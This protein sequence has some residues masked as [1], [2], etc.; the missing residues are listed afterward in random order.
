M[1]LITIIFIGYLFFLLLI[2]LRTFN[3]NKTQE[4]YLLAGS[5]LGPWVTAFSERASGESAWMFLAFPG[6]AI[7][8]GL[9]ES[10]TVIG[11]ILGIIASWFLIA[12]KLRI[13]TEKF[14]VLTIPDY[15]HQK[16][17]DSTGIIRL[18][19]SVI[20]SFFYTFYVS[21]QFHAS[22]KILNLLTIS[23]KN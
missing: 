15:L 16:Y 18:F 2:G 5:R 23:Y 3:F 6:A 8:I 7:L 17:K 4:D 21:A 1:D 11:L 14:N 10:W 19:S 13:E 22:G 9:G 20:I 12:E